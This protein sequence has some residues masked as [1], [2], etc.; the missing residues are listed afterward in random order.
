M[1]IEK[2]EKFNIPPKD[3][4]PMFS[5]AGSKEEVKID[6]QLI[7]QAN[8]ILDND[9]IGAPKFSKKS[10]VALKTKKIN[11]MSNLSR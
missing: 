1:D 11:N 9:E 6:T 10:N 8:N 3:F 2:N 4:V 5:L 7:K